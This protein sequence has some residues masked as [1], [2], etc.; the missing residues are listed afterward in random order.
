MNDHS[1]REILKTR[2]GIQPTTFFST[3]LQL[4]RGLLDIS[5]LIRGAPLRC[6]VFG[7]SYTIVTISTSLWE[8]GGLSCYTAHVTMYSCVIDVSV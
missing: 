6:K 7:V 1:S 3:S 8:I 2:R 4:L 5:G